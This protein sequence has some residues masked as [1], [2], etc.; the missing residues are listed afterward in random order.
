M[1]EKPK[2]FRRGD[3]LFRE[4]QAAEKMYVLQKGIISIRKSK[5]SGFIE[6]ARIQGNQVVGEL[7]FFD[8][9]RR[10]ASAYA[11]S[12]VEAIEI[13][14]EAMNKIYEKVPNYLKT[15][16]ESMAERLRRTNDMIRRLQKNVIVDDDYAG[17]TDTS[18][19]EESDPEATAMLA[20]ISGFK[21]DPTAGNSETAEA[22]EEDEKKTKK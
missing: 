7:S 12:D 8:R 15:I 19:E 4:G 18:V 16:I 3:F 2:K 22:S 9:E 11:L 20:A 13:D 1:Q 5:G 21:I 6:V 17:E 14:F 10:S